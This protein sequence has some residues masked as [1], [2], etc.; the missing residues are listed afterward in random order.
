NK[1]RSLE[2]LL[3]G[4]TSGDTVITTGGEGS[5]HVLAT[6]VHARRI[7]ARVIGFRWRHEMNHS[8]YRI[9]DMISDECVIS[10]MY[11]GA[12]RAI[13]AAQ[14][15]RLTQRCRYVPLGGSTPLG[16][17]AHVNAALELAQQI[18]AGE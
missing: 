14:I 6:A 16:A 9:A 7:G 4:V 10:R 17:L 15:A 3:A 8:A 11:G 5:T 18:G 1:A 2:F 12:T 13:L